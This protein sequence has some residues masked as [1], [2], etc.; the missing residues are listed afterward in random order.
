MVFEAITVDRIGY[1]VTTTVAASNTR[2]GIYAADTGWVPTGAALVDATAT[3]ATHGGKLSTVS[4]TLTPGRYLACIVSDSAV[5]VRSGTLSGPQ[6]DFVNPSTFGG[7]ANVVGVQTYASFTYAALPNT[8]P[9]PTT[10][11]SE[12]GGGLALVTVPF[13]NMRWT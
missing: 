8:G 13:I 3:T 7:G 1:E 10:V 4:A 9:A 12:G 2:V 5:S 6:G 11:F